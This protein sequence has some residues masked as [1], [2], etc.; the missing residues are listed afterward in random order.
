M[1]LL[2]WADAGANGRRYLQAGD[3]KIEVFPSSKDPVPK[4]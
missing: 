2:G 3:T 1:V 4:D